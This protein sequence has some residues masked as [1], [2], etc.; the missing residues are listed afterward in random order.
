LLLAARIWS[1][2][3]WDVDVH[4]GLDIG[5]PQQLLLHLMSVPALRSMG[6]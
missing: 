5:V 3:A 1:E 2:T 6:E 4:G